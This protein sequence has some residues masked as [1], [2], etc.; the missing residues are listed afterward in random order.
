[1]SFV[2]LWWS[3]CS[4]L[5]FHFMTRFIWVNGAYC[6]AQS[7]TILANDRGFLY[8]DGLFETLR[9]YRG[10]P[11]R[12]SEHLERLNRSARALKIT[13]PVSQRSFEKAIGRLLQLNNLLEARLRISLTRGADSGRFPL[14]MAE[15]KYQPTVVIETTEAP[16]YQK[17]SASGGRIII[18]PYQRSV[19]SPLYQ[20]KTLNFLEN[21]IAREEAARQ[22]AFEAIF[23]NTR[24]EVAEGAMSN[25]FIVK[26]GRI[27]TPP[28]SAN[29]LPGITRKVIFGLCTAGDIK[30]RQRSFTETDLLNAD[31]VFI[32][33]SLMEIIPAVRCGDTTFG[34]GLPGEITQQLQ[35]EYQRLVLLTV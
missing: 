34:N 16:D 32:T 18:M 19:E 20:H 27:Y 10:K 29:I 35:Q 23:I 8:G 2:P 33:G 13:L 30:I 14:R 6:P 12:L 26:R 1:V 22:K 28:L 9:V 3:S 7:G 11:F 5:G 15:V 17:E 31:E 25:V 4:D 21:I 24:D